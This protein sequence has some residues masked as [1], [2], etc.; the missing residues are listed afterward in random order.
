MEVK[1]FNPVQFISR[2]DKEF[3]KILKKRVNNYFKSN[4]IAKTGDYRIWIK[5]IVM[6]LIYLIPFALMLTN[7]F[8]DQLFIFY[9]LWIIMGIGI[10]GCGLAI[11]HDANHGAL[12]KNKTVNKIVGL[13]I[14]L[15]GGSAFTWK[16]QHN[17]LHHSFTNVDGYDEDIDPGGVMRFSPHQPRKKFFK[18]QVFYAWFL[19]GLM[20]FTWVIH[21]DF[22]QLIRY[23]KKGLLKAQ[24]TT[25]STQIYKLIFQK[26]LYY[27]YILVIPL[28]FVDVAWYHLLLG[29]FSMHFL[30]GLI[31]ACVFQPAHVLPDTA[32]PLPDKN[33]HVEGNYEIHQLLT[34]ANFAP[35]NRILSW[36]VGG[37]NYQIE[38]HLF[39][40]MS[41][42]HHR[43]VSKIVKATAKE[44]GLPYYSEKT[45]I[46]AIINHAKMINTL[47]KNDFV[48]S[49]LNAG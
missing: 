42:V 13:V 34:T 41:H 40:Q 27:S 30:A 35:T 28:L 5:V 19:Y 43:E 10:A 20:T 8:S 18:Y 46:G 1:D 33:N 2:D 16:I 31:L 12:S 23:N 32:F 14:D 22:L 24:G 39:P 15:A 29:W 25:L 3:G 47:G 48:P 9:G 6:P 37:L 45:F 36:Y 17:V 49:P 44:F 21:K 38:H 11:M 26:L 4:N 7:W